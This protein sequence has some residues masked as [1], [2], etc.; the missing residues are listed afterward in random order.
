ME[1]VAL[2]LDT[3]EFTVVFVRAW[4]LFDRKRYKRL[5]RLSALIKQRWSLS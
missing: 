4:E 1:R 3:N 2:E 5:F